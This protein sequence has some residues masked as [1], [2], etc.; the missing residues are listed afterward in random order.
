MKSWQNGFIGIAYSGLSGHR[1]ASV[2]R[3]VEWPG[4]SCFGLVNRG[5]TISFLGDIY[6]HAHALSTF[7]RW[8][9]HQ[10]WRLDSIDGPGPGDPERPLTLRYPRDFIQIPVAGSRWLWLW[11]QV[12][13]S[14]IFSVHFVL[15]LG[16]FSPKAISLLL[17]LVFLETFSPLKRGRNGN[18]LWI[19][20]GLVWFIEAGVL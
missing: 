10:Y 13:L 3:R 17:L 6:P 14:P 18:N 1:P 5:H 8:L 7:A 4:N 15:S 9:W 16:P 20:K 19:M 2:R 12:R 11:A